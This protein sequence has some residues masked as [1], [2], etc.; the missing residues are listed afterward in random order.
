MAAELSVEDEAAVV[1]GAA[2]AA[3]EDKDD[4][5]AGDCGGAKSLS[6]WEAS[7]NFFFQLMVAV[8]I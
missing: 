5:A 1:G 8:R 4:P 6:F 2:A 3:E 7:S